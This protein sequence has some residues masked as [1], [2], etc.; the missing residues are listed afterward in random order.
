L[1]YREK[2]S[3]CS[4]LLTLLTFPQVFVEP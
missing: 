2:V 4:V 1:N 3:I